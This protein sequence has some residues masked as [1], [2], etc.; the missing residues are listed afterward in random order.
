MTL[1]LLVAG[2]VVLT[3]GAELLVR[4]SATLARRLGVAP[5]IVG[6]TVVAFGTSAPEMTVSI[7]AALIGQGDVALGNVVGSNIFNVLFILGASA[8]VVP[9]A[10]QSQLV[11]LDV[12]VMIAASLLVWAMAADGMLTRTEGLVLFAGIIAYTGMQVRLG[13]R[14]ARAKADAGA[15]ADPTAPKLTMR[16]VLLDIVLAAAGLVLLVVGAGWF[17][18]SAIEIARTFG[19]S[20]LVIGLT[21]VAAGTSMPEVAA[22]LMAAFR[23]ERDIAVGNVVG[24]N[25]FNLLS[26]LGA[27][28][29]VAPGGL[30]VAPG[31]LAFDL[32]IMV[33][34][35][36][37]CLPMFLSG[38]VVSR[39]EGALLLTLQVLYTVYLILMSSGHAYAPP[40]L[41]ALMLGVG[42]AVLLF[43]VAGVVFGKR[44][45]LPAP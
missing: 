29:A 45:R 27:S 11:R 35:A 43:L 36:V 9:L 31:A 17:I 39:L 26:V 32:P 3:A 41:T 23:G 8:L 34:V 19:V 14:E 25:L 1:L 10:V 2:L 18:G 21:L 15:E 12:P 37:I 33:F 4:G 38:Y 30:A 6:L 44:E 13:L 20:E 28:A 22:S 5:L 40:M 42:P 16:G 24:S 7:K